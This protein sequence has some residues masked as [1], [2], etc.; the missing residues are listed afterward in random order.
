MPAAEASVQYR[1]VLSIQRKATRAT[2]SI[3]QSNSVTGQ[4]HPMAARTLK[5]D[6]EFT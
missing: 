4:L 2:G 6:A 5:G 3:A 1:L